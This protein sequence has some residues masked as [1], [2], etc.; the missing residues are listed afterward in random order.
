MR[1]VLGGGTGRF[2]LQIWPMFRPEVVTTSAGPLIL[3]S[4]WTL[5]STAKPAE[6]G[7]V[8]IAVAKGLGPTVPGVSP[9]DPFPSDPFAAVTSPVEVLVDGKSSPAINQVDCQARMICITLVF[10]CLIM[11]PVGRCPFSSVRHG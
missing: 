8:L 7:E 4:D 3:H 10:A 11:R 5:V 9:G 6:R 1:R 2:L